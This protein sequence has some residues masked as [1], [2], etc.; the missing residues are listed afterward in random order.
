MIKRWCVI[1]WSMW[2]T[3][4][5]CLQGSCLQFHK[6]GYIKVCFISFWSFKNS[7]MEWTNLKRFSFVPI[8][9]KIP[10]NHQYQPNCYFK[11]PYLRSHLGAYLQ[12]LH[13]EFTHLHM[14]TLNVSLLLTCENSVLQNRFTPAAVTAAETQRWILTSLQQNKI[15]RLW[16]NC[17]INI[18]CLLY[19]MKMHKPA[20]PNN[21]DITRVIF[22]RHA[23]TIAAKLNS[24]CS[25]LILLEQTEQSD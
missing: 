17:Q 15:N 16:N 9:E 25:V 4:L 13:G 3:F 5:N 8:E 14:Q 12:W 22:S 7:L 1:Y 10:K 2:R 18:T 6:E 19:S 11:D 23:S 24:Y 20:H 21:D